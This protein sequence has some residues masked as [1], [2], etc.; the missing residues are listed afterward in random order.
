MGLV[1]ELIS[2]DRTVGPF[3][4]QQEGTRHS[5]S[6]VPARHQTLRRDEVRRPV[7]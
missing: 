2:Y 3:R 6:K 4:A 5:R 7:R 1:H